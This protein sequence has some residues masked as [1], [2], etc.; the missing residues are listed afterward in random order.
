MVHSHARFQNRRPLSSCNIRVQ[1]CNKTEFGPTAIRSITLFVFKIAAWNLTRLMPICIPFCVQNLE[2]LAC[3]PTKIAVLKIGLSE[4]CSSH[5]PI[6]SFHKSILQAAISAPWQASHLKFG[7]LMGTDSRMKA[8]NLLIASFQGSEVIDLNVIKPVLQRCITV[9][10]IIR[11]T[12]K[13][14]TRHLARIYITPWCIVVLGFR[15]VGLCQAAILGFK[16]V[17]KRSLD[18]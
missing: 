17:T 3:K 9:W 11:R 16:L 8:A 14:P 18:Q 1:T 15:T 12:Y 13:L 7:T 2:L 10:F 6:Q 5:T 4:R